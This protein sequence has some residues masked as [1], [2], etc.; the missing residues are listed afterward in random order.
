[1]G[2]LAVARF[3]GRDEQ[4]ARD[5]LA[6]IGCHIL[7]EHGPD[8]QLIMMDLLDD[9][10]RIDRGELVAEPPAAGAE[11]EA[12][13][14]WH[15]N[16]LNEFHTV[17]RGEGLLEFWTGEGVISVILEPGDIMANRAGVEHRYRPLTTH[18]WIIRISGGPD[19]ELVATNTGRQN[20]PF[21]L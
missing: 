16:N 13:G 14:A 15:V 1:M 19:V 21:A 17:T 2:E 12:F 18:A 7:A 20:T 3:I 11:F 6:G 4:E 5:L 8:R 10:S 9:E